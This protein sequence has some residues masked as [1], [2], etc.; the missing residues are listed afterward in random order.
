[1]SRPIV[2]IVCM[3]APPNRGSFNN[4]HI[5]G[6]HV[7]GGGAVHSI[8]SGSGLLSFDARAAVKLTAVKKPDDRHPRGLRPRRQRAHHHAT[9]PRDERASSCF[10]RANEVLS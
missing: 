7:P 10:P 4:A 9:K 2:V 1:M 3:D 8:N 6:T 5:F